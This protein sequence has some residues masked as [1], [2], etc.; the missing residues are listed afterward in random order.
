MLYTHDNN[1]ACELIKETLRTIE[2]ALR[3]T[4][5]HSSTLSGQ[6]MTGYKG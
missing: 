5:I 6:D 4:T 3:T 1:R 2:E